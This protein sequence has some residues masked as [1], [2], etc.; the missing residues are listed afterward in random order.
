VWNPLRDKSITYVR[1]ISDT[2]Q[3]FI[4]ELGA[5]CHLQ[6]LIYVMSVIGSR[7]LGL[8]R[9]ELPINGNRINGQ[10]MC[11]SSILYFEI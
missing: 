2:K 6:Y 11:A 9:L 7:E 1:D 8:E 3:E 10:L 5:F 4:L